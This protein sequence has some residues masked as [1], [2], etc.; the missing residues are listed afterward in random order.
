MQLHTSWN[1]QENPEKW[2]RELS[3]PALKII[4]IGESEVIVAKGLHK[5]LVKMKCSL[6]SAICTQNVIL[7]T[8]FFSCPSAPPIFQ[9]CWW[10]SKLC[11]PLLKLWIIAPHSRIQGASPGPLF[12]SFRSLT[13]WTSGE[14]DWVTLITSLCTSELCCYAEGVQTLSL[15]SSLYP[16]CNYWYRLLPQKRDDSIP[17]L[18]PGPR[19]NS[20][21]I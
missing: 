8:S 11:L 7:L 14:D 16:L 18:P 12:L 13:D 4:K 5:Y 2:R 19:N 15:R 10:S 1:K 21:G 17:S 3:V 20:T 6:H 9:L